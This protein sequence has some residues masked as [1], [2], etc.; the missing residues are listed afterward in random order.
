[1]ASHARGWADA[2]Q[3]QGL[4]LACACDTGDQVS[5]PAAASA[6]ARSS[7]PAGR[8]DGLGDRASTAATAFSNMAAPTPRRPDSPISASSKR[9]CRPI[10]SSAIS[11]SASRASAR[12]SSRIRW[13][14]CA[15]CARALKPGGTMTMIVWRGIARQSVARTRQ[16]HRAAISAACPAKRAEL[17]TGAVFHG[18][19]RRVTEQ[20]EIAAIPAS[21]EAGRRAG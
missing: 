17:R 8:S 1:M 18:G 15:T 20:L 9:T 19:D 13:P 6:T 21:F 16:G 12:S 10:R 11:I 14:V 4:S 5:T 3:R 7:S 2:A